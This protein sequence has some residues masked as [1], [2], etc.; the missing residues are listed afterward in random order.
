MLVDI[1]CGIF[2]AI[3][4]GANIFIGHQDSCPVG[5]PST[6]NIGY[7]PKTPTNPAEQENRL[8]P[9]K[10]R[11]RVETDKHYPNARDAHRK[12][13][14]MEREKAETIRQHS[15]ERWVT[16]NADRLVELL[17]S[18]ERFLLK[19]EEYEGVDEE[20]VIEF[21]SKQ[22]RVDSCEA[23]EDGISVSLRYA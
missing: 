1:I 19:K 23:T 6:L 18:S 14:E 13:L 7:E 17:S 11:P 5:E 16:T 12:I 21:L 2:G 8:G 9:F 22:P 20:M 15:F 3:S 4:L 10:V